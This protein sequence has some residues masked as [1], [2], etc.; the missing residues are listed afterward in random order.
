M[1]KL[2]VLLDYPEGEPD[3]LWITRRGEANGRRCRSAGGW[4]PHAFIGTMSNL[5][6]YAAGEDDTLLTSVEDAWHTM[7][8]AE[9][10]FES[11][12]APA[13]PVRAAP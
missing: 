5:Q 12:A 8:L 3:E 2:G 13:T 4:F 1:V 9:A 10:A 6:R 11:A 7:A